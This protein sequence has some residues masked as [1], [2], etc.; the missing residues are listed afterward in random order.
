MVCEQALPNI[1][2]VFW[3]LT[4]LTCSP[5]AIVELMV[6]LK[7]MVLLRYSEITKVNGVPS[8]DSKIVC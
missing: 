2:D 7:S 1:K 3:T 4:S 6:Y 5:L 8:L